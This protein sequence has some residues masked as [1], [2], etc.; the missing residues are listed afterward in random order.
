VQKMYLNHADL[1]GKKIIKV[2]SN[3][4]NLARQKTLVFFYFI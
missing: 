4:I 1:V 2:V 3:F